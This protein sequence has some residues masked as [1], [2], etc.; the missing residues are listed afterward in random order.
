MVANPPHPNHFLIAQRSEIQGFERFTHLLGVLRSSD[1]DIHHGMSQH[2]PIAI[3]SSQ[4]CLTRWHLSWVQKVTPPGCGIGNE[5][6]TIRECQFWEDLLL[7]T[8]MGGVVT[9]VKKV[10]LRAS[11]RVSGIANGCGQRGPET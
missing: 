7:G 3:C 9:E 10:K 6:R 11:P 2:K 5:A 8:S 4:R 1:T